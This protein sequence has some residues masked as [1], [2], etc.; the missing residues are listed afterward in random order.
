M[1]TWPTDSALTRY[2]PLETL[3]AFH[4][5]VYGLPELVASIYQSVK[6]AT[7]SPMTLNTCTDTCPATGTSRDI[8]VVGLNGFG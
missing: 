3:D 1:D 7:T 5:I 2:I 6:V 4:F 8:L